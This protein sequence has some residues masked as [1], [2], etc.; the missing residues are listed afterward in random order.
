MALKIYGGNFATAAR[1]IRSGCCHLLWVGD[2]NSYL[3]RDFVMPSRQICEKL[4][5]RWNY[6]ISNVVGTKTRTYAH[7]VSLGM[8]DSAASGTYT[9]SGASASDVTSGSTPV[10]T[11][12][13]GCPTIKLYTTGNVTS[14]DMTWTAPNNGN[15][16][17]RLERVSA[18]SIAAAS[19]NFPWPMIASIGGKPWYHAGT[20][21][22]RMKVGA[23]AQGQSAGNG[24]TSID[25]GCRRV[26]GDVTGSPS[27]TTCAIADTATI[28][29]IGYSPSVADAGNYNA[30]PG[31]IND[32]TVECGFRGTT[33]YDESGKSIILT[34]II[35]ARCDS[36]DAITWNNSDGANSGA[37]Y[38]SFGRSGAEITR[39]ETGYW[40]QT[41][42]QEYFTASVLVPNKVTVMCIMLGHNCTQAS[43][44][45]V[46]A[47]FSTSWQNV[48][49]KIK[50][51]YAAAHPTGTLHLVI[52]T[53]WYSSV[54]SN[55]MST[56]GVAGGRSMQAA[57]EALAV[58]NA[59]SWFSFFNYFNEAAPFDT[60]HPDQETY[61]NTLGMAF[62][63]ALDRATD[64]RYTTRGRVPRRPVF[65]E[66]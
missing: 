1:L 51:A 61:G 25:I 56:Q 48:L 16:G 63:D 5:I 33:G 17:W 31:L 57:Y 29:N 52:V 10:A 19:Q 37:G 14:T 64:Y 13:L 22:D 49:T 30:S 24:W 47:A 3:N 28:Q 59:G 40:S 42:W 65:L 43:G 55:F 41:Q 2:S 18:D 46:T 60:L 32:H 15:G 20:G 21:T 35:Y 11:P 54:E 26:G 23:I 45:V 36:N 39:F 9:V 27:W 34:S 53:P 4:P 44:G 38:D 66:E 58:A 50:A 7:N 62:L 8:N 12:V 6:V